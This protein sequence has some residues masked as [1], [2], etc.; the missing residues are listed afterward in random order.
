[1]AVTAWLPEQDKQLSGVMMPKSALLWSMDQAF[2][3]IKTDDT[4]SR[5]AIRHYTISN[6]GY[7][8]SEDLKPDEELVITGA[9][10]LLSEEMR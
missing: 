8:V 3:Y 6:E 5:R 10:M 4:F 9:Q 1:M 7:F 2:V